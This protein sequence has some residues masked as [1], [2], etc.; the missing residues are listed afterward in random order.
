MWLTITM[1]ITN[2]STA[3]GANITFPAF[4]N[5]A[6]D[7]ENDPRALPPAY[8]DFNGYTTANTGDQGYNGTNNEV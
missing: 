8:I 1:V 6:I 2:L 5:P 3:F 7:S 4:V